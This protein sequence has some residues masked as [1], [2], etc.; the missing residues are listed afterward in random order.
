MTLNVAM[1]FDNLI[2]DLFSFIEVD[3]ALHTL[4]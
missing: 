1:F 2:K 4:R 3:A